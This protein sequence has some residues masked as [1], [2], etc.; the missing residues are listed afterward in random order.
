MAFLSTK[1]GFS[2]RFR[3]RERIFSRQRSFDAYKT[4]RFY[5]PDQTH[6]DV[7]FDDM[8]A[9]YSHITVVL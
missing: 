3:A 6:V 8:R 1:L 7:T 2:Y 9:R 4:T 5:H